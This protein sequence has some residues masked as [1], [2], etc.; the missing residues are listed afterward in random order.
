MTH[1]MNALLYQERHIRVY[2][3][4]QGWSLKKDILAR[5]LRWTVTDTALSQDQRFLVRIL[6]I[7]HEYIGYT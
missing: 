2:N 6:L 5:Q 4:E 1:Y 7:T 3:T